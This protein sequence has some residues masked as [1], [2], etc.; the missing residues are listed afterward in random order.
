MSSVEF[1]ATGSDL[2]GDLRMYL[3]CSFDHRLSDLWMLTID[4]FA[5]VAF[6][7]CV[8]IEKGQYHMDAGLQIGCTK[9]FSPKR[10]PQGKP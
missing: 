5:S 2:I 3:G 6:T 9:S 7:S 8:L 1:D 10:V 4:P